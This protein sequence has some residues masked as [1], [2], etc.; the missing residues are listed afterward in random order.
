MADAERLWVD[1]LEQ[2]SPEADRMHT[3]YLLTRNKVKEGW[4][5]GKQERYFWSKCSENRLNI[6][7]I[8]INITYIINNYPEQCSVSLYVDICLS[9]CLECMY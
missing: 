5:G 3:N 1:P 8:F 7:Y 4:R 2:R 6:R 9:I